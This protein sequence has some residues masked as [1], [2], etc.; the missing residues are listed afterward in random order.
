MDIFKILDSLDIIGFLNKLQLKRFFSLGAYYVL[1][2]GLFLIT[3]IFPEGD[4]YSLLGST[5]QIGLLVILFLKP[6]SVI[7]KRR[8]IT[9]FLQFR[10][11]MGVAV[12]WLALFH[13]VGFIVLYDIWNTT[14]FFDFSSHYTYGAGALLGLIVLA[15]TSNDIAV[16]YLKRNWKR[17]QMLAYPV[18]FLVFLHS[19]I[20]GGELANFFVVSVA[21]LGAKYWEWRVTQS[22]HGNI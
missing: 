14:E 19:S 22:R 17:V 16:R 20:A 15:L 10:R 1:P 9:Y 6:L 21:F 4:W 13:G 7:A 3:L 12:F 8:E 2:L 18:L 11:Q 5:A